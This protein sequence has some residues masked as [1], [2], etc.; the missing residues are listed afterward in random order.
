MLWLLNKVSGHVSPSP[1]GSSNQLMAYK[2]SLGN[3]NACDYIDL[4]ELLNLD[5]SNEGQSTLN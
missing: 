1:T 3:N 5:G 4:N 2:T